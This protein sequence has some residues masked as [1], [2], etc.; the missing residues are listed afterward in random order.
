MKTADQIMKGLKCCC[1][2]GGCIVCPYLD[3]HDNDCIERMCTDASKYIHTLQEITEEQE[4]IILEQYDELDVLYR[5]IPVTERLPE[6]GATCLITTKESWH[7]KIER[8]V[9]VASYIDGM[10][11]TFNDWVEGQEIHVTHW[12]P[13]PNAPGEVSE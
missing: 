1:G 13:L 10:W 2:E 12:T 8:H 11:D 7:G 6:Y 5:W 3:S 9:D 4:Q